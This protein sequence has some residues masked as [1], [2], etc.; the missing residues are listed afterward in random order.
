MSWLINSMTTEFGENYMLNPTA[1]E[2]WDA[3]RDTYSCKENDAEMFE[4]ESCLRGLKQDD[5]SVTHYF[6]TFNR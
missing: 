3:T 2:I 5:G 1:K 4:I 6:S